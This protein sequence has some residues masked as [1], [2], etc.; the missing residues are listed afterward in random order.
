M[1]YL[2]IALLAVALAADAFSVAAAAAPSAARKW[3]PL[4]MS[5][6]FGIFQAL[7]PLLGALAGAF[8]LHYVADYDHW[9]AFA[10]LEIVG[11]KMIAG[12]LWPR[13]GGEE[14]DGPRPDPSTGW[15][16][17]ALALATS[18]DAFGAGVS[19]R[20]AEANLWLACPAIGV[21]CAGLTYLGARLGVTVGA[22]FGKKAEIAGGAVLIA[23]G[24]R[25]LW[26]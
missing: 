14:K 6:A 17:L 20:A 13:K 4:R 21:V 9:V 1:G 22:R 12:A 3:G 19:M 16:L 15:R 23:L 7:M 18:I 25:M 10:L 24:V 2:E 26:I 8:L 11:L 5:V